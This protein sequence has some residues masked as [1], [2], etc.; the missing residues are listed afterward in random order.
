M[1]GYNFHY[2]QLQRHMIHKVKFKVK[3]QIER[4]FKFKLLVPK[5]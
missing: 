5:K 3:G 2:R 4:L 1:L